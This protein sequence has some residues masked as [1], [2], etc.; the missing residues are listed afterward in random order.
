M[1]IASSL[2][3]T[4]ETG[5]ATLHRRV[6]PT[7]EQVAAQQQRWNDLKKHLIADLKMKTGVAIKSWLQGS[8][9]FGTQVRPGRI[10]EEFDVDLG[11]YFKWDGEPGDGSLS[12]SDLRA[13]TQE[14]LLDY[15]QAAEDVIEVTAP[16]KARC[17]RIRFEDNFHVDVPVYHLD[18]AR[19][20]RTLATQDGW[21]TSDPKA[22]YK[23]FRDL[24]DDYMRDKARRHVRYAKCWASL[25]FEAVSSRPSSVLLTVLVAEALR[26]LD[27]ADY[28][29]DDDGFRNVMTAISRRLAASTVVNNPVDLDEHLG[30]RLSAQDFANFRQRLEDLVADADAACAAETQLDAA[31]KWTEIFEHFFPM[32]EVQE[33]SKAEALV[34]LRT[35]PPDI[36]VFVRSRTNTSATWQ[37]TNEIGPIPK[38]CDIDFEVLAPWNLP[39]GSVIEWVVRNQDSEAEDVNDLGHLAGR[40]LK[41]REH[42]AY[43]GTHHMDCLIK[44]AGRVVAYRRIPVTISGPFMNRAARRRFLARRRAA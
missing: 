6:R 22:L 16:P 40:G 11:L 27:P 28:E 37:G 23:W 42:S 18:E 10:G 1:G 30:A 26:D 7:D 39:A 36:R 33:A 17:C 13:L 44:V 41:V 31:S 38:D 14:S 34:S 12:N 21:E 25:K 8:Y 43:N 35:A 29:S 19:D 2:F 5:R 20:A 9:K 4:S 24:F 32:P 15:A 3:F